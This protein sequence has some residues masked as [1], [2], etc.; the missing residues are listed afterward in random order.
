MFLICDPSPAFLLGIEGCF[1]EIEQIPGIRERRQGSLKTIWGAY[2]LPIAFE[3][4]VDCEVFHY[5][6]NSVDIFTGFQYLS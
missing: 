5:T 1:D 2:I 3:R 4:I 6:F